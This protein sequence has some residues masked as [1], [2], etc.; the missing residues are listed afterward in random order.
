MYFLVNNAVRQFVSFGRKRS[1][2]GLQ[3]IQTLALTRFE[4]RYTELQKYLK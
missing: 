2:A 3:D 1:D 4:K